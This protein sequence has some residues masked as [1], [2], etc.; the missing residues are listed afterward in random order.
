M[1]MARHPE[2]W[3]SGIAA[4]SDIDKEDNLM[5][6]LTDLEE[7]A[8]DILAFDGEVGDTLAEL[9]RK[10]GRDIP[11]LFDQRFDTVAV[12]Y[13]TFEH[14]D[15]V[16]ALGQELT[17]FGWGLYDF[18]DEDEYLFV[19][20]PETEKDVFEKRCRKEGHY[21]KLMKQR[22]RAWGQSAKEQNTQPLMPCRD[23][24]FPDNAYYAV[25]YVAGNFAGGIW[26]TKN[27]DQRGKFVADLRKRPLEPIKV[28]W[29][30]FREFTYSPELEF[31]AAIYS[32]RYAQMLAGGK[33]PSRVNEW[34]R[35]TPRSMSRLGR[36]YWRREYLCTGDEENV[37]ILKMNSRD[38]EDVQ[39]FIL[40]QTDT[41]CRFAMDGLGRLYINR[42]HN[43]S[44]IL[45]YEDREL[46]PHTFCRGGYDELDNS[47]P[48]L[49]TSR[50]LMIRETWD[51]GDTKGSLL[52]LDMDTGRCKIVPLPGMGENL[53]LRSFTGDWVLIYN[54]GDDFRT[55]FA[56]LW[57]QKT[58]EILRIRP[59]MFGPCKPEQI[60]AL[61]DGRVVIVTQQRKAGS[62]IHEPE[63]FWGF[64]RLANKPKR[65]GKWLR[66]STRYPD[67]PNTLPP[68]KGQF[69]VKKDCL[70]FCG[71][72]LVPPFTLEKATDALGAARVVV[73]SGVRKDAATGVEHPYTTLYY[74]WDTL[75]IQGRVNDEETEIEAF[76]ICLSPHERNLPV[77]PFDGEVL[78]GGVD[79]TE[80]GWE[81]FGSIN[82]LK[83]GGFTLFTRLPGSVPDNRDEN[84]QEMLEYH[85]SHI[86]LSYTQLKPKGKA[87]KYKL[88]KVDEPVLKFKNLNFKLAVINV[89]M[90][91]KSLLEP[92][93]DI[94]EFAG[95]YARR[96]I[97]PEAEGYDRMVPEAAG[98]FQRYP[99][100]ARLA[101]EVTGFDMDG[102]DEINCQLAPNWDGEDGLFDINAVEEAELRQFPN[103]SRAS[104]FTAN[105]RAV[106]PVFRKCGI[107]VVSAYDIPF[108][109]DKEGTD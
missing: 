59:G 103:L 87:C 22:G 44:K 30:N 36:L 11:A 17:T 42:G 65:L 73:K 27:E 62:V 50:L 90:Y 45:R 60:A 6:D 99:I 33:D 31:Y 67:I 37:L 109:M 56:W 26:I 13:M 89:L 102:G 43:G 83:L 68:K 92:R 12:Q 3:L 10:W 75:G 25:Q 7:N 106:V 70:V 4:Q 74:V 76:S 8:L 57:N 66:Y 54:S 51:G 41:V 93:F 79:Y 81:A 2:D 108:E 58:G 24:H 64:L 40:P 20:L 38:A 39:R 91:E 96:K 86:E 63:D 16:R 71:K 29:D 85:T 101:P 9:R 1:S 18:D 61:P 46:K 100:P 82:I 21:F 88:P 105:E 47:I 35:L 48:V 49:G 104:I 69:V 78:I 94:W 98:W 77:K 34:E 52:D 84:I 97:N 72:K 107:E 5:P 95:E 14:E 53:K 55:D 80:A 28:K 15:G 23:S 19:L 32:T